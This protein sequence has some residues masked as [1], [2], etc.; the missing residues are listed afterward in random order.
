MADSRR[1]LRP[2]IPTRCPLCSAYD[3][4]VYHDQGYRQVVRCRKCRFVSTHPLPIPGSIP[5]FW[6]MRLPMEVVLQAGNLSG[7]SAEIHAIA[8]RPH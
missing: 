1:Q 7:M 5:F 6:T 8:R 2:A 4:E 3:F